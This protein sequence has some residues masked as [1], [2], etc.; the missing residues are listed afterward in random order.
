MQGFLQLKLEIDK[1]AQ[2][3][4]SKIEDLKVVS[5]LTYILLNIKLRAF[6]ALTG[7]NIKLSKGVE[8][9][10]EGEAINEQVSEEEL[11]ISDL[12]LDDDS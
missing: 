11:E 10:D 9:D 12:L 4:V 6:D 8:W 3:L 1:H 7:K 5:I 2:D